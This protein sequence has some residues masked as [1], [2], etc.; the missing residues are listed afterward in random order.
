MD[1]LAWTADSR[2][3][4]SG[5]QD[6]SIC[7]W[8]AASGTLLRKLQGHERAVRS[9]AFSADGQ[10]LYSGSR[11]RTIR[12]WRAWAEEG[13]AD[14]LSIPPECGN[15]RL[16]PHSRFLSVL[17]GRRN[18]APA[19]TPAVYQA[20][21]TPGIISLVEDNGAV[22]PDGLRFA[23]AEP[24]SNLVRIYDHENGKFT[25]RSSNH[26]LVNVLGVPVFSSDGQRL[27]LLAADGTFG[28][29][30]V[31]PWRELARWHDPRAAIQDG[32]ILFDPPG[33][34]VFLDC[35]NNGLVVGDMASGRVAWLPHE[36]MSDVEVSPDNK[37]VAT[38]G[39][40]HGV[41]LWAFSPGEEP[42]RL[43]TI[44]NDNNTHARSV[45]FTPDGRRLAIGLAN[46]QIHLW[47]TR[48]AIRVAI[49]KGHTQPVTELGFHP[50][51]ETLVS[52]SHHLLKLW[53]VR[54]AP[55]LRRP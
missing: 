11:D 28:V 41:I 12:Q 48:H 18:S 43:L 51:D 30:Q 3:L 50:D 20:C 19:R 22:S 9:I 13:A 39:G 37:F 47:D 34:R 45:A 40:G 36:V 46:G 53:R 4:A 26:G 7:L 23:A 15:V 29:W 5:S 27:A 33:G 49:L 14:A 25:L 55:D 21:P 16:A 42:R 10:T 17:A 31:H 6:Q 24:S 54:S 35:G 38:A 32:V 44:P 2:F 52:V 8:N 1:A